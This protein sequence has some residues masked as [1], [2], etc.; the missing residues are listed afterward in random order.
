M[1]PSPRKRARR[2]TCKKSMVAEKLSAEW[3]VWLA[4][5][6]LHA[7]GGGNH[8]RLV[9]SFGGVLVHG[10]GGLGAEVSGFLVSKSRVLTL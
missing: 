4:P 7:V 8:H 9:V 2:H 1:R 6:A 10:G 3:S 5:G